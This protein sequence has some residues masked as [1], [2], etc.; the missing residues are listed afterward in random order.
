MYGDLFDWEPP[1]I[2]PLGPPLLLRSLLLLLRCTIAA[3]SQVIMGSIASSSVNASSTST[4]SFVG[5]TTISASSINSAS[6]ISPSLSGELALIILSKL[7]V[8]SSMSPTVN[9]VNVASSVTKSLANITEVYEGLDF[10]VS[11][12]IHEQSFGICSIKF[13]KDGR[14]LIAA[15]KYKLMLKIPAHEVQDGI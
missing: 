3:D 8:Y 11:Q 15:S 7:I 10:S 2:N 5:S 6:S 1:A 12:N 13:S 9:V 14:E 4:Y